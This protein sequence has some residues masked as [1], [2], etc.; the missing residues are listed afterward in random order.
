MH[1]TSLPPTLTASRGLTDRLTRGLRTIGDRTAVF[2]GDLAVSGDD[3][4]RRAAHLAVRLNEVGDGPV[5]VLSDNSPRSVNALLGVLLS[6]R[7]AVLLDVAQ[8]AERLQ[9][10][11]VDSGATTLIG[12]PHASDEL[13]TGLAMIDDEK[14]AAQADTAATP[15]LADIDANEP[16]V[17]VYTSGSTGTPK[18]VVLSHGAVA[19]G[20]RLSQ[21]QF[22]LS[23]TDRVALVAPLA[24]ALGLEIAIMALCAGSALYVQDPRTNGIHAMA[25]GLRSAQV[26]TLHLTPSLLR[27]LIDSGPGPLPGVRL[28]TTAGEPA[29][30]ADI[31]AARG[32]LPRAD[33]VN[34]LGSSE[35]GHLAF[36]RIR[37]GQRVPDGQLPAGLPADGKRIRLLGEDGAEV[38]AGTP[39]EI[40][41]VSRDLALGYWRSP[42]KTAERFTVLNSGETAYRPH[43]RG[44]FDSD[45]MLHVLGRSDD[46]LKIGGYLVEPAE[47][48]GALRRIPEVVEATVVAHRTGTDPAR[49]VAYVVP[50]PDRRVPSSAAIRSQLRATL[51]SWMA[52]THIVMLAELPRNE[53]GKI[54]RTRLPEPPTRNVPGR[55]TTGW[56]QAVGVEWAAT[57]GLEYVGPEEQFVELGGDSLA[58]EEMLQRVED[59]LGIRLASGDLTAAPTLREFAEVVS[60]ARTRRPRRN[61]HSTWARLTSGTRTGTP[62][63]CFAG[64]G[65]TIGAFTG[66]AAKIS[67]R[68]SVI[69]FQV[70]GLENVGLPDWSVVRT[71]RRYVRTIET[72]LAPNQRAV[73]VGHSLGGLFALE[74][75]RLLTERGFP[76]PHIVILDTVLPPAAVRAAGSTVPSIRIPDGKPQTRRE[77]WRTRGR[78]LGAGLVN[79][80][81]DT[82]DDVFFQ[83]GLR[84]MEHYRPKPWP[85]SI[86]I[87]LTRENIDDRSWWRSMTTHPV[88][89]IELNCNHAAVLRSP[90]FDEIAELINSAAEADANS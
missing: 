53:R 45:G 6:G 18:G 52:P 33:Y 1:S 7:P 73:L 85:G 89:P 69:A 76:R 82:R 81:R 23:T 21:E 70:N 20:A 71:A 84:L 40:E 72:M 14:I 75:G 46:A 9:R 59:Q 77:L 31:N 25:D 68:S 32:V 78:L 62:V 12:P 58:V 86:D 28:F 4:Y 49:L 36:F 42:R 27:A 16:A 56:E 66:L 26:T 47:V 57:L 24:F 74:V 65:G 2:S 50:D 8:P 5:A 13:S 88:T 90:Y 15:E 61:R 41:I 54:D 19:N 55:A 22:G 87:V 38:P 83:H 35:T 34:Y 17:I 48:E 3:L 63:F 64:A 51:P 37:S 10:I 44:V 80:D 67:P 79:Y 43:D 60:K 30:G 39:G 11:A 29:Q